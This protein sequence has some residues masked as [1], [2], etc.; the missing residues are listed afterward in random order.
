MPKKKKSAKQIKPKRG[1]HALNRV[2]L[3][4]FGPT[5]HRTKGKSESE[6][7]FGIHAGNRTVIRDRANVRE[8]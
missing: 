5:L 4:L 3:T 8:V 1:S 2:S 7:C 6:R